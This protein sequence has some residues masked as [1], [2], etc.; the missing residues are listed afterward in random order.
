MSDSVANH[1]GFPNS[2]AACESAEAAAKELARLRLTD[3]ERDAIWTAAEAY[4]ENS[5]D[6]ECERLAR[7]LQGI[8]HRLR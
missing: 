1:S 5:D 4:A 3:A 6:P 2:S 7:V 8:Y